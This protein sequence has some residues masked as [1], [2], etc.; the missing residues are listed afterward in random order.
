MNFTHSRFFLTAALASMA[1]QGCPKKGSA[2]LASL[3]PPVVSSH[4]FMVSQGIA[5]GGIVGS[6][7]LGYTY[8][9]VAMPVHGTLSTSLFAESGGFAYTPAA[10]FTGTDTF[11]FVAQ[12][13]AGV[14]GV[15]TATLNVIPDTAPMGT[16]GT[17]TVLQNSAGGTGTLVA[18]DAEQNPVT[19]A[20]ATAPA[21][22]TLTITNAS[23][24]AY[25][26]TP[27]PGYSGTDTFTFTASDTVLNSAPAAVTITVTALPYAGNKSSRFTRTSSSEANSSDLNLPSTTAFTL[28][29]WVKMVGTPVAGE[30]L[31]SIV[32]QVT[33]RHLRIF[34]KDATT[35]RAELYDGGLIPIETTAIT[36]T[37]WNHI[38]F[39]WDTIVSG[40]NFRLFVD[41][42]VQASTA[43]NGSIDFDFTAGEH[44]EIGHYNH[45]NYLDGWIDDVAYWNTSLPDSEVLA[46]YDGGHQSDYRTNFPG[47]ASA[48]S[49]VYNWWMGDLSTLPTIS[50]AKG[51]APLNTTGVTFVNDA[52]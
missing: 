7:G 27:S 20:I 22:G 18:V 1:L 43:V 31:Y 4:T 29:L 9:V 19:Y 46:T 8:A 23:S 3:V 2:E 39:T 15:G 24:G 47:Y 48:G 37:Q 11:K 38:V 34:W 42:V 49:L 28:S 52:P 13:S 6:G 35:L 5:F 41:G 44:V 25:T 16:P 10:G 51:N 45:A 36:P 26:Y 17:L 40:N 33:P 21:H 12:N 50:P 30:S 14:S 32:D